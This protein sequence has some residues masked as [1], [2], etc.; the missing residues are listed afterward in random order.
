MLLSSDIQ[1]ILVL[2]FE[3]E[4]HDMRMKAPLLQIAASHDLFEKQCNFMDLVLVWHATMAEI[5]KFVQK[6]Q[7]IF[8]FYHSSCIKVCSAMIRALVESTHVS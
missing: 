7:S 4:K 8:A 2:I 5:F 3:I 1:Q 6:V